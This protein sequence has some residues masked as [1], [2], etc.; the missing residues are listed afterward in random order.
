[1]G[2]RTI[3]WGF[4]KLF[5]RVGLGGLRRVNIGVGLAVKARAEY[6]IAKVKIT[7][8]RLIKEIFCLIPCR[9]VCFG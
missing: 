2:L 3:L 7:P 8:R 9:R 6:A 1:M 5:F 4:M